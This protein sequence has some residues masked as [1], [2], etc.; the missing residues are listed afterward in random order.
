MTA[1][2]ILAII[3]VQQRNCGVHSA[4]QLKPCRR[5]LRYTRKHDIIP[6]VIHDHN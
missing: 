1:I 2:Y 3:R 5:F 6:R 4:M